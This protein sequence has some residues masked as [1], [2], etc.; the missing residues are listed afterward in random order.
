MAAF[1]FCHELDLVMDDG[2][3]Q[4]IVGTFDDASEVDN[5]ARK[6]GARQWRV[7]EII[8]EEEQHG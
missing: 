3:V 4:Y 2:R 7:V 5:V 8:Q 6:L 1:V